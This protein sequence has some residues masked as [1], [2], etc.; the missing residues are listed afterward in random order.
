MAEAVR[1]EPHACEAAGTSWRP[2]LSLL[3]KQCHPARNPWAS[4]S[5][6]LCWENP[7][8]GSQTAPKVHMFQEGFLKLKT[9]KASSRTRGRLCLQRPSSPAPSR[10][11]TEETVRPDPLAPEGPAWSTDHRP[12]RP[13]RRLN[14][15]TGQTVRPHP[16]L[17]ERQPGGAWGRGCA[18]QPIQ[19]PPG[20]A[21]ALTS[22]CAFS[23]SSRL[24]T[25]AVGLA[26]LQGGR[27]ETAVTKRPAPCPRGGLAG[28]P[29]RLCG[30]SVP[31]EPQ[32]WGHGDTRP[33]QQGRQKRG[34]AAVQGSGPYQR[35]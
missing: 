17:T 30:A 27:A 5:P 16:G 19:L 21:P 18:L 22:G 24:F 33:D 9:S 35:G 28:D 26:G 8:L 29:T 1:P 20:A 25:R 12:L 10:A 6:A 23:A 15:R 32:T 3:G 34:D 11:R 4:G 7:T 14:H 13:R 31:A 2:F